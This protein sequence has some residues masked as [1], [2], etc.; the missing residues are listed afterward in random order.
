[1]LCV[2]QIEAMKEY[3]FH[4]PRVTLKIVPQPWPRKPYLFAR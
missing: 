4:P 3:F 1:V 2:F